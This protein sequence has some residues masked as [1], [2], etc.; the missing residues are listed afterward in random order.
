MLNPFIKTMV[1]TNATRSVG[2]GLA[3]VEPESAMLVLPMCMSPG[4][5]R[6]AT[7]GAQTLMTAQLD[8]RAMHHVSAVCG[9]RQM[10]AARGKSP[11]KSP[12]SGSSA[13][14]G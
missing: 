4:T 14:T 12:R 10:A 1:K 2:Q 7:V 9:P 6:A 11:T 13:A 5:A 8:T 3:K